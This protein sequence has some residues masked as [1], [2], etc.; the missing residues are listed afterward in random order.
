M[1]RRA[2]GP[3]A[4]GLTDR[5]HAGR[6]QG[7]ARD[8]AH[9]HRAQRRDAVL[10]RA[11]RPRRRAQLRDVR[12]GDR[13]HRRPRHHSARARHRP[14]RHGDHHDVGLAELDQPRRLRPHRRDDPS[15]RGSHPARVTHAPEPCG[16]QDRPGH[17]ATPTPASAP[18]R[19][20]PTRCSPTTACRTT[21]R[22]ATVSASTEPRTPRRPAGHGVGATKTATTVSLTWT[23][24]GAGDLAGVMIR[25]AAGADPAGHR[26]ER[27][28][29]R[30]RGGPGHGPRGQRAGARRRSTPT[31]FRL[32]RGAQPRRRSH[33]HRHHRCGV[34]VGLGADRPRRRPHGLGAGRD[35]RSRRPTST[36]WGRSSPSPGA[37]RPRS[38]AGCSTP[39]A[40]TAL[41]PTTLAA[42]DLATAD[43]AWQVPTTGSCTGPVAVTAHLVI[44]NCGGKPRAYDRSGSHA[45]VWDVADTDPGQTVQY[46]L[47]IGDR[48]V[49]WSQD[50]VAAYRLSD[51]QRVWQQLLPAGATF[52]HDVAASGTTVVVAYD[53]RLR[54]LSLTTGAQQWVRPGLLTCSAR[55]RRRLGLR[56]PRGV[57][58]PVR[59]R[60][61]APTAGRAT[62]PSVYRVVAADGDTVYVWEAV[63]DFAAPSPS[64]L[65]ALRTSDGTQRW[66]Y[67]VPS[68]IG[69]VAVTG[70]LVWLTSTGD[71]QPG[72]RQRPDRAQAL[73]RH[74]AQAVQLRRQHVRLDRCRVRRRQG[75]HRPG[76]QLRRSRPRRL[77]VLG[78]A[79][80]RARDRRQDRSRSR[81][82]GTAYSR[83]LDRPGRRAV[84]VEHRLR[85]AADGMSLSAPACSAARRP[86]PG[87]DGCGSR[88]RASNGRSVAPLPL[89][90][91]RCRP[92]RPA[93]RC[94]AATPPATRS[95]SRCPRSTSTPR[96]RLGFRWK[97][98]APGT[99]DD[100]VQ[101]PGHR[102][103]PPLRRRCRRRAARLGHDRQHDEPARAVDG[104]S[105]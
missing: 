85:H 80:T 53:D 69:S 61:R 105:R 78:L 89:A 33:G 52:I 82:V 31:P 55:H 28:A 9:G 74:R 84:P 51:G 99:A 49:A 73:R 86:W 47:V 72:A 34:A 35:R 56:P 101:Q 102:R 2:A 27:H 98:A 15:R 57:R 77:R 90:S 97:T 22:R 68:R 3:H 23:N 45:V 26:V 12:D 41:G 54:A 100:P 92:A 38:P 87:H 60:D 5:R 79:G 103:H 1:I 59:A 19:S 81:Y 88:S 10:L 67:D 83:Q 16:R 91:R 39:S 7:Q 21:R 43:A 70:D 18:G 48:L 32:R 29:G 50:R 63:F 93:G 64:I 58:P 40:T 44:V 36:P 76:R 104:G 14:L 66:Q 94:S 71:L 95:R 13:D 17:D 4:A 37:A 24:P 62:V 65:H 11:V 8:D 46:H 75:R 20:T 96:R 25:R 42:Y 30:E 6:R